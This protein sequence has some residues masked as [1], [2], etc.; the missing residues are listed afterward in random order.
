MLKKDSEGKLMVD[1]NSPTFERDV[2]MQGRRPILD[3]IAEKKERLRRLDQEIIDK[4]YSR[5]L[6]VKEIGEAARPLVNIRRMLGTTADALSVAFHDK[7]F[8][9][10]VVKQAVA[11]VRRIFFDDT[12]PI[13]QTFDCVDIDVLNYDDSIRFTFSNGK[14]LEFNVCF[15]CK[16]Y[17]EKYQIDNEEI[18]GKIWVSWMRNKHFEDTVV[19]SHDMDEIAAVIKSFMHGAFKPEKTKRTQREWYSFLDEFNEALKIFHT[20]DTFDIFRFA[21]D[22]D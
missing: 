21:N 8:E 9:S 1:F 12:D 15:P 19:A 10:D 18:G 3:D 7:H 13:S 4:V 20:Y 17:E 14:D 16:L 11:N 6:L 22:Q 2:I 5:T